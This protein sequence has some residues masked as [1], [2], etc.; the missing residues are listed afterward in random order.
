MTDASGE[1]GARG[2]WAWWPLRFIIFFVILAALDIGCQ[3][4]P[5]LVLKHAPGIP[6]AAIVVGGMLILVVVMIAGYRL[7]VRW[8]EQRN[9]VE[10]GFA[11]A[12]PLGLGGVLIGAI[13][14]SAVFATLWILGVASFHGLGKTDRLAVA[15]AVSL[16]AAIGEEIVFR[17][18]VYRLFEEGFGTLIAVLLSGVLFG[19]LH[20]GNPGATVASSTAIALEAGVLLA[21]AY[22]LTRSLWLPIGLHFGW[23]F[24]EGGIFGTSV[25]GGTAGGLL[26]TR[27]VGPDAL[28]GGQF[29]PEASLPAVGICFTAAVVMLVLA[30]Q[31]GQWQPLRFRLR[32]P[33]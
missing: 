14:F 24:T 19:L 33:A 28:T 32:A 26:N 7:L 13:L 22:T 27:L 31:R 16:A 4:L 15:L 9:P 29:G 5:S 2:I 6:K 17:G 8:M 25:S 30:A 20:A 12:L 3:I 21:S 10:L 23:N 1:T 11:R 18:V